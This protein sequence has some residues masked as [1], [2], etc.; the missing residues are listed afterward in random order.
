[1]LS[2]N[3]KRAKFVINT[4]HRLKQFDESAIEEFEN[5]VTKEEI[6]HHEQF[7]RLPWYFQ[8]YL[9][10]KR[11]ATFA[12]ALPVFQTSISDIFN[13]DKGSF[14]SRASF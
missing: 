5:I 12:I 13:V 1:M 9:L 3:V 14:I 8:F 4:F 11:S 6:D 2:L 10:N 7:F